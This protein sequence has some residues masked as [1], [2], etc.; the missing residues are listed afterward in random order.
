[1]IAYCGLNCSKCEARAATLENN[2][3]KRA[4]VAAKWTKIYK[5]DISPEQINCTGCKDDG[6]KF[7]FCERMCEIRKCCRSRKIENCAAC[8]DF[9]CNKL[10]EFI[11]MAPEAGEALEKLRAARMI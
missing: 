11:K 9:I 1:M 6:V 7:F 5:T 3:D 4:E 2:D 10:A 8:D